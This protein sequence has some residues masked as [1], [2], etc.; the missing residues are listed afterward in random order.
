MKNEIQQ[1]IR[2]GNFVRFGL[3]ITVLAGLFF[4]IWGVRLITRELPPPP[5]EAFAP[6][7]TSP[8]NVNVRKSQESEA[9]AEPET[10]L[11]NVDGQVY[12][13]RVQK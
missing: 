4:M 9:P 6:H 13:G 7:M 3:F 8:L 12:E 11:L 1:N 2:T 5:P 10:V